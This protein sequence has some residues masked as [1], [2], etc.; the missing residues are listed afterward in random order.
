[1]DISLPVGKVLVDAEIGEG[2]FY[3][4]FWQPG[5]LRRLM[6]L[7]ALCQQPRL[8]PFLVQLAPATLSAFAN[9][10]R[11]SAK[12]ALPSHEPRR[13]QPCVPSPRPRRA[14]ASG[15]NAANPDAR[16]IIAK[17]RLTRMHL[18]AVTFRAKLQHN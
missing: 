8:A 1:M 12:F 18:S 16:I 9:L 2:F 13:L 14:T 3:R 11:S 6:W 7:T 10:G 4:V 17:L 5:S 15:A